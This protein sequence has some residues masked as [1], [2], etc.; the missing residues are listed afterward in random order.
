[1]SS[2]SL[3]SFG[4]FTKCK[5]ILQLKNYF[6]ISPRICTFIIFSPSKS[7]IIFLTFN[8][9]LLLKNILLFKLLSYFLNSYSLFLNL[10]NYLGFHYLKTLN[11]SNYWGKNSQALKSRFYYWTVAGYD[12]WKSC[13]DHPYLISI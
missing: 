11:F 9:S 1:M 5:Q 6:E 8:C 2:H 12:L 3:H 4:S 7:V 13:E 10:G